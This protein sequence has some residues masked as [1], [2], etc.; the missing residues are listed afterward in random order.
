MCKASKP[1]LSKGLRKVITSG[2]SS[3]LWN[4]NW[5]SKG[6]LRSILSNPLNF[7]EENNWVG[8]YI[9]VN[10]NW[11]WESL[12]FILPQSLLDVINAITI[13]PTSPHDDF[14]AWAPTKDVNFSLTFASSWIW[15][16]KAPQKIII[17]LW[18]C[19]YNS[20]LVREVLGSRGF[21]LDKAC[22]LCH[23]HMET[24]NHLLRECQFLVSFWNQ[25]G[26]PSKV[27]H[28]FGLPLLDWLQFN[29]TSGI[30][31][32]HLHIPW[33]ILILFGLWSLWLNRNLVAYQGKQPN[34]PIIKECIAK[35]AAC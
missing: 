14:A 19:S 9:V 6:T 18:L 30:I 32:R 3:S 22:P 1:L 15:K 13:N 35:A 5:S 11:N 10:G 20:I 28:S 4:D 2:S 17:F 12:S 7:Q 27:V 23:S 26:L 33:K 16:V 24:I 34:P 8:Q 29:G 21:T 25:L 31:S